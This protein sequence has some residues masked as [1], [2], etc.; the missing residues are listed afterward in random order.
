VIS[1]A[2]PG[3]GRLPEELTGKLSLILFSSVVYRQLVNVLIEAVVSCPPKTV[4]D[5][6][7]E[8]EGVN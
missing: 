4:P 8:K 2:F 1:V 7:L 6:K 5:I 3:T